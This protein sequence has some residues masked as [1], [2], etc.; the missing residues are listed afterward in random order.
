MFKFTIAL[1]V[2]GCTLTAMTRA[3][4]AVT[5]ACG[6]TLTVNTTFTSDLFCPAVA[7]GLRVGADGIT[8]DLAGF[9]L[10]GDSSALIGPGIFVVE[11]TDVDIINGKVTGFTD[12]VGYEQTTRGSVHNMW[13]YENN[14][15]GL[16][17]SEAEALTVTQNTVNLNGIADPA[18]GGML[19]AL[20]HST[21]V[22]GNHFD[23]NETSGVWIQISTDMNFWDNTF[24][25]ND[26][27]ARLE[28]VQRF[29][30]V[31]NRFEDNGDVG[32]RLDGARNQ[33]V[34]RNRFARNGVGISVIVPWFVPGLHSS[35]NFFSDNKFT[36]HSFV[37][38]WLKDPRSTHIIISDNK[39]GRSNSHGFFHHA[40]AAT[41]HNNLARRND[42]SGFFVSPSTSFVYRAT[43]A[44]N[45]SERNAAWGFEI[46]APSAVTDRGGNVARNNLMGDCTAGIAC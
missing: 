21:R 42:G 25:N 12:G 7:G 15:F 8:I 36:D 43:M 13:L 26:L 18:G 20:S 38:I 17:L 24:I 33:A 9:V 6:S 39:V 5:P 32:L 34:L 41:Y 40:G 31:N 1:V 28:D 35:S 29:E 46:V 3:A 4:K 22:L 27:G 37:A 2:L 11:R 44:D 19:A 16:N 30:W 45:R 14:R 10:S 23:D